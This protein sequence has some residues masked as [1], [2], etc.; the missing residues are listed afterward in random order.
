LPIL[1]TKAISVARNAIRLREGSMSEN[2]VLPH[3]IRLNADAGELTRQNFTLAQPISHQASLVTTI[4]G[5][6]TIFRLE[7]L[8]AYQMVPTEHEDT[9]SDPA[10]GNE[11][12]PFGHPHG[13]ASSGST[14]TTVQYVKTAHARAGEPLSVHSGNYVEGVVLCQAAAGA[15]SGTREAT[16]RMTGLQSAPVDVPIRF[17]VGRIQFEFLTRP[18]TVHQDQWTEVSFRLELPGAPETEITRSRGAGPCDIA[19]TRVRVPA[20]GSATGT[21]SIRALSHFFGLGPATIQL[22]IEGLSESPEYTTIEIVVEPPVRPAEQ[23]PIPEIHDLPVVTSPVTQAD[24]RRCGKC[25]GLF[26]NGYVQK[27]VCPRGGGHVAEGYFY[28]LAHD[29]PASA[30][31]QE[32]WRFCRGCSGLFYDGQPEKGRCPEGGGHRASGFQ[33]IVPHTLPGAP[34]REQ[35]WRF[36]ARCFGLFLAGQPGDCPG[37][38]FHTAVGLEFALPHDIKD[39]LVF[40]APIRSGGLAALGGWMRVTLD[41]RGV[42]RW[43]GHAHDSG[44]DGYDFG[45]SAIVSAPSGRVLG[46]ARQGRVGGSLTSGSRDYDWDVEYL[47]LPIHVACFA[48][49]GLARFDTT[50]HYE[51]DIGSMVEAAAGWIVKA[52]VGYVTGPVVGAITFVGL[53]AGSYIATGS[54]APGARLAEGI[55]WMAGPMNTLYAVAASG[56][57]SAGSRERDVHQEEYDWANRE[58]FEGSL[59]PR[60]KLLLTDTIGGGDRAFT[61]PRFDGRISLN[62]GPAAFDD[63]RLYHGE[64]VTDKTYGRTFIHELV[65]ACQIHYANT[66]LSLLAGALA[67]KLCE[68][69][70]QSP[71]EYGFGGFDFLESNLE[72]Q[73]EVVGDWFVG[74]PLHPEPEWHTNH[75]GTQRDPSPKDPSSPYFRYVVENVRTGHY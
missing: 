7:E 16:L 54:M 18:A 38:G 70:G 22:A 29:T 9:P 43:Q 20:N 32:G 72:Q 45:V 40:E 74:F 4:V 63:P 25:P 55:L 14:P 37:G 26:F 19:A 67:T 33:F 48:D 71:Y 6:P 56:L 50:V 61:F 39:S 62:F 3:V 58:V 5:D 15:A 60:E 51:S 52:A 41:P 46:F 34:L 59:P 57:A 24:W 42:M 10:W 30:F 8:V 75:T 69:G 1:E 65:H 12:P 2:T 13:G 28:V 66:D 27:G 11:E 73:A 23:P 31:E 44:A 49:F 21:L 68:A 64:N 35:G 36:C 17:H 47:L 53:S